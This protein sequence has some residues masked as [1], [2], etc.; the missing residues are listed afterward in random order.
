M[1]SPCACPTILSPRNDTLATGNASQIANQPNA[2]QI[3][4][5]RHLC[6]D[7]MEP[8]R[9]HFVSRLCRAVVFDADTKPSLGQSGH[10]HALSW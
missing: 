4:A 5:L 6:R 10:Q 3:E 9:R 1:L 2:T 7:V 8:V